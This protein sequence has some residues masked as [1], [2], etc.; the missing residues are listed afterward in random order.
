[1]DEKVRM[2]VRQN[3]DANCSPAK[4]WRCVCWVPQF[5]WSLCGV[6]GGSTESGGWV[7]GFGEFADIAVTNCMTQIGRAV[8][9]AECNA[10]QPASPSSTRSS[11]VF[12]E[13]GK[14]ERTRITSWLYAQE[15]DD[16]AKYILNGDH[17]K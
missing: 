13:G 2:D 9:R 8:M 7:E 5:M 10:W 17:L 15:E 12:A 4:R 6:N 16:L 1:M 11:K 14:A 3:T